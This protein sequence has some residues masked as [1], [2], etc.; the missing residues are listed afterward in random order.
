VALGLLAPLLA[1]SVDVAGSAPGE[2]VEFPDGGG[3]D[4]SFF[5]DGG[6]TGVDAAPERCTGSAQQSRLRFEQL[7][8]VAPATC[9]SETQKR[10]CTGGVYTAWSGT[11]SAESC[12]LDPY[13]ACGNV[14]HRG[15]EVRTRYAAPVAASCSKEEQSRTCD[16]GVFSDWSG[17]F[18]AERCSVAFLGNCSLIGGAYDCETGTVCS[19]K[20]DLSSLDTICL[21]ALN[22]GCAA[23]DACSTGTTCLAGTCALKSAPGGACEEQSDCN[24]NVLLCGSLGS[25]ISCAQN[26]CRCSDASTCSDNA[27]CL[28]TCVSR[29]C[30]PANTTCD[31]SDDC[32]DAYQCKTPTGKT[33]GC[34]LPDGEACT[35]NASCEHVCRGALCAPAGVADDACDENADCKGTL[36]CR[37]GHCGSPGPIDS[38]AI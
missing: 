31:N 7:Q 32:R 26:L 30:V 20:G 13:N 10:S 15:E 16:D 34:Y 6:P 3:I 14:V 5:G 29:K 37:A 1:C 17:T 12:E 22:Q 21:R 23:N 27:Q 8:V 11:F 35:A 2:S 36:T 28:G 33:K 9:I 18:E 25:S 24:G 38:P 19:L 4:G